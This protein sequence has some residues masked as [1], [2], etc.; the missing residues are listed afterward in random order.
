MRSVKLA[1]LATTGVLVLAGCATGNP[2]VAAYV[3]DT[4]IT[5]AQVDS[6]SKVLANT[7]SDPTDTAGSF[8][9]TVLQIMIQSKIAADVAEAK[10][11]TITDTQRQQVL[12]SNANL[13]TLAKDPAATDFINKYVEAVA[14]VGTDAGKS[15]FSDQFA[16]T[17]IRVNPRFGVWDDA[18][19]ALVDGSTGSISDVAPIRQE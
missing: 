12:A 17:A 11:I 6:V 16:K 19:H 13:A 18:H 15:A 4:E 8:G 7:S 10:A 9:T 14:V 3:G 1:A 5:Q 2:Q